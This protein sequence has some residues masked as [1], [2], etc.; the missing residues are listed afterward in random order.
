MIQFKSLEQMIN[1]YLVH[2]DE[3]E[4]LANIQPDFY[5]R[6]KAYI[7][8]YDT[9]QSYESG[10]S[11]AQDVLA[12]YGVASNYGLQM[13]PETEKWLDNEISRENTSADNQFQQ[14]MRDTS[15]TSSANQLSALGLSP[16]NVISVGGSASGVTSNAAS[17][18]RHSAAALHQQ[19]RINDYNNKMGLAKTLISAAG[20][21]ASSGIYGAALG[22]IKHSAAAISTQAAHS[23]MNAVKAF[24]GSKNKSMFIQALAK[25]GNNGA[26]RAIS[27]A[28]YDIYGY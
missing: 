21:M 9:K 28:G 20:S 8:V 26:L 7:A 4:Q 24:E 15:I 10:D 11:S 1:Y 17:V 23:A 16:S 25:D 13:S 12:S 6:L 5:N 27:E 22:A 18:N 14:Q 3:L 2:R 19:E